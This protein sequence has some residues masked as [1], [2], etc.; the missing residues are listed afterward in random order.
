MDPWWLVPRVSFGMCS[1]DIMEGKTHA[2]YYNLS[3]FIEVL[4]TQF[5]QLHDILHRF[6][7]M[8]VSRNHPRQRVEDMMKVE[9]KDDEMRLNQISDIIKI[10]RITLKG[11]TRNYIIL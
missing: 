2:Q 11:Y 8:E 5:R 4:P 7:L 10:R 6:H 1:F 3:V 9:N